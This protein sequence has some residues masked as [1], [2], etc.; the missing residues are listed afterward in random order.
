MGIGG[1]DNDSRGCVAGEFWLEKS[2]EKMMRQV[3]HRKVSLKAVTSKA[4]GSH[5]D[6]TVENE[7]A[8]R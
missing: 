8:K 6:T 4:M 2:G 1:D 3:I 5:H 7:H